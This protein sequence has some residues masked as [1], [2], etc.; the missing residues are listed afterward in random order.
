MV[1]DRHKQM[2]AGEDSMM[3]RA[4]AAEILASWPAQVVRPFMTGTLMQDA[5]SAGTAVH[6]KQGQKLVDL[7]P[8][9]DD[10]GRQQQAHERGPL[11]YQAHQGKLLC[12]V[13]LCISSIP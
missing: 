1:S 3:Y 5:C 9:G 13:R 12:T 4:A 11:Q 10:D 8:A 2:S 7:G 6:T